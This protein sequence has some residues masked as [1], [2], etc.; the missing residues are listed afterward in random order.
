[1]K[2]SVVL[3]TYN[4]EEYIYEQLESL[5]KQTRVIDEV[6]IGDDCSSDQTVN[7]CRDFIVAN[8]LQNWSVRV[9]E[10]NK[11]WKIN[12]FELL[13]EANGDV[14][15][16]CDQDDIWRE[17]KIERMTEVMELNSDI[18]VLEGQPCKFFDDKLEK[19]ENKSIRVIIGAF[20]DRR[21]NKKYNCSNSKNIHKALFR[22]NF[23]RREPGCALAIR[24]DYFERIKAFWFPEVPH[25]AIV[26]YIAKIT[27]HYYVMDYE[28][29]DWRQH[30]GSASRPKER[31]K[32]NRIKELELDMKMLACLENYI[33][34]SVEKVTA[35]N[36]AVLN[37]AKKWNQYRRQLVIEGRLFS[38]VRLLCYKQYYTQFRRYFTDVKYGLDK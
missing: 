9:N 8:R 30:V 7:I 1:M 4:G 25:D 38:A 5:R 20:F 37:G 10:K 11:G 15:F 24:K 29:L 3:S 13:T 35:E 21:A 23:F 28:V 16:P 34:V 12:F 32:K 6:I 19:E 14:I 27:G 17:D 18:Y 31:N 26:S 22:E 2:V 36:N 33:N